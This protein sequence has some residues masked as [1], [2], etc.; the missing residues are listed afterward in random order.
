MLLG[1]LTVRTP[2]EAKPAVV[3]SSLFSMGMDYY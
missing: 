2:P 3:D 1:V